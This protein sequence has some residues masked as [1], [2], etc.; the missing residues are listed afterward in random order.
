MDPNKIVFIGVVLVVAALGG[1][2][3]YTSG[4]GFMTAGRSTQTV[5]ANPY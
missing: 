4:S 1:Y 5:L 3:F 2:A